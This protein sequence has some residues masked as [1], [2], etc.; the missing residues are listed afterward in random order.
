MKKYEGKVLEI[1]DDGSAVVELPDKLCK[2]LGWNLGDD[3]SIA[4]KDGQIILRKINESQS[5]GKVS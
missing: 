1:L 4:M 5:T 3:L 2:K